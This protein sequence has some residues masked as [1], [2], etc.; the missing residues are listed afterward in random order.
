M[1][2]DGWNVPLR[3]GRQDRSKAQQDVA[4]ELGPA[5]AQILDGSRGSQG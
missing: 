1:L 5:Q 2:D 4:T 3:L